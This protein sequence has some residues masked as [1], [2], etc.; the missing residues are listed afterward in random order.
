MKTVFLL[1]HAQ[2]LPAEN[3]DDFERKLSPKGLSDALMLGQTLKVGN[4]LPERIICSAA[5]RTRQTC[6]QLLQGCGA[7]IHTEITKRIYHAE[8]ED[9]LDIIQSSDDSINA[10]MIIGHNPTIYELASRLATQGADTVL[11][12]L[13]QGYPPASLSIIECECETWQ[14]FDRTKSK[15]SALYDPLDYNAPATPARWT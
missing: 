3:G 4:K 11:M 2:A 14:S 7:N 9:L 6:E 13:A 15:I 8:Y 1:R 12:H 5:R 10:L